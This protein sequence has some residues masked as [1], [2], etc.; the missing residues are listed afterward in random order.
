MTKLRAGEPARPCRQ[1]ERVPADLN[2]D[3]RD[4]GK[5]GVLAK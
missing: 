5:G 4:R 2:R 1:L 3:S